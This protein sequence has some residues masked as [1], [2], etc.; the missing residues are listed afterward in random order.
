MRAMVLFFLCGLLGCSGRI[1]VDQ[2]NRNYL[3]VA[4]DSLL[5]AEAA[6]T[7]PFLQLDKF[8]RDMLGEC[9]SPGRSPYLFLDSLYE[10]MAQLRRGV[11]TDRAR[12]QISRA[13]LDALPR[14][15]Y[16]QH[17]PEAIAL[18]ALRRE[19]DSLQ[20]HWNAAAEGQQLMRRQY[21]DTIR[22]YGIAVL[23]YRD[24]ADSLDRAVVSI[25][26]SLELQ[27]RIIMRFDRRLRE[28]FP[29]PAMP[30]FRPLYEV[31]SQ[32]QKMHKDYQQLWQQL[33]LTQGRFWE[34][35]PEAYFAVGPAMFVPYE[36]ESANHLMLS[37]YMAMDDFRRLAESPGFDLGD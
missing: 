19:L 5:V 33:E 22:S 37:L 16:P 26:D 10:A 4:Q 12:A 27:G 32:L 2:F 8:H 24:F 17:S 31:L 28:R 21:L 11:S 35:N 1:A 18:R 13:E 15:S 23:S 3:A 20:R 29:D 7:G 30:G 25:G 9:R 34:A 6:V 36:V 14:R